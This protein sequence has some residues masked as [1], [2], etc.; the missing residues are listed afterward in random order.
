MSIRRR[1][2]F[3]VALLA[4]AVVASCSGGSDRTGQAAAREPDPRT[5]EPS[6]LSAVWTARASGFP[7]GM[8]VDDAGVVTAGEEGGVV[9]IDAEGELEWA[10]IAAGGAIEH[11]PA[12]VADLVAVAATTQVSALERDTG[13]LRW[14]W[15]AQG[16][17][18]D[19]GLLPAVNAPVVLVIGLDGSL[20]LLDAAQGTA[21]WVAHLPSPVPDAAPYAWL[22]GDTAVVAWG[23]VGDCCQLLGVDTASGAVRWTLR[24]P[25]RSTVPVV[26]RGM[27]LVALNRANDIVH[28][29]IV[30]L[31]VVTGR[32]MWKTQARGSFS[33]L[34]HG[35]A[36]GR[37]VVFADEAGA[38][39]LVDAE[40]GSVRWRSRAV[41]PQS[42]A[43]PTLAGDRVFLTAFETQGMGFDRRTGRLLD[44]GPISPPVFVRQET[45][46]G[47][48][49]YMLVTTN[50]LGAVW[51]LEPSP[52]ATA[53]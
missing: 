33:P 3:L 49:L 50:G 42:S 22:H 37:E 31:D 23:A 44:K 5:E 30:A 11:P 15:A 20:A 32:I 12:L 26:H 25:E 19:A 14:T 43:H 27:V 53:R 40:T 52:R 36:D 51:A 34:L 29:E 24:L 13:T 10:V 9:A 41:Y 28:A 1:S 48:R 16:A 18:V 39:T 38:V 7:T 45:A 47:E 8:A 6:E 35:D 21:R 4:L 17:R 46:H 2:S